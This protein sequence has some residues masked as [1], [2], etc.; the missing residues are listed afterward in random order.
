[1]EAIPFWTVI[2]AICGGIALFFLDA[3][4]R[5]FYN[6][7]DVFNLQAI[8][9]MEVQAFDPGREKEPSR[10]GVPCSAGH[11]RRDFPR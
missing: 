5:F 3:R 4:R 10:D 6:H 1:M 11:Y 8:M 2:L 9:P 7:T